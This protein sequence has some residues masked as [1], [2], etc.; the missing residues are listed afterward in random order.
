M[1]RHELFGPEARRDQ[2]PVYAAL[3]GNGPVQVGPTR[4]ALLDHKDVRAA[5][6]DPSAFSSDLSSQDNPVFANSPLIF[7]DPPQHTRVR[8]LVGQAFTALT[9]LITQERK[10]LDSK[11]LEQGPQIR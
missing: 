2:F 6:A 10:L 3:R 9:D 5:L 11:T 7:D 8:K 4:W 1:T